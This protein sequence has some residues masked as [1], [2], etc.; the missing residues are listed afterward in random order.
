MSDP[1]SALGGA[2]YDGYVAIQEA[3][4]RGMVTIRGDLASPALKTAIADITGVEVPSKRGANLQADQGV[5]WMSPDE[6]MVLTTYADADRHTAKLTDALASEHAL[7]ANVSDARTLFVVE[8][9]HAREVLAKVAPV[10]L[11]PG[12]FAP[13]EMRRTRIA[14]VPAAFWMREAET[15]EVLCFRSVARYVFDVLKTGALPGAEVDAF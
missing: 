7:V 13:G 2:R 3:P 9:A 11:A 8:G 6:L 12:N 14:Q 1:R 4:P 5:L 15:F 10:D